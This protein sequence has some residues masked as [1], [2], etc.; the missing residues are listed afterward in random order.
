MN[1]KND[2]FKKYTPDFQKLVEYGFIKNQ[3]KYYFEKTFKNGEFRAFIEISKNGKFLGKVYDLE[4]NDEFLL[5][6]IETQSSTFASE[7]R[8]EYKKILIDIR[9]NCFFENYFI[10]PQANR[11]SKLIIKKYGTKPEFMW[12]K[13]PTYGVFK[14]SKTNK[15]YGIIMYIKYSKLIEINNDDNIEIINLK[16]DS[17][18]IQNLLKQKSFFPAWHMNKKYWITITLDETLSDDTILSFI[19]ESYSYTEK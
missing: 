2:I 10:S 5:L 17:D 14:N 18:K 1:I 3:D 7:I 8:E 13:F 11:I 9:N 15:W 4:N 6:N 16:L 19:E 12:K